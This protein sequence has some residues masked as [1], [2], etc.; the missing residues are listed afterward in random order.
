LS[1]HVLVPEHEILSSEDRQN[2]LEKYGASPEHFPKISLSDPAIKD[3]KPNVGDMVKITRC[4]EDIGT[5]YYFRVV[6]Q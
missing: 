1:N 5:S 3:M 2:V 4:S 6:I